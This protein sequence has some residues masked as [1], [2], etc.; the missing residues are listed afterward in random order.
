MHVTVLEALAYVFGRHEMQSDDF[1]LPV[2]LEAFPGGQL[3]Q[4]VADDTP[5]AD[6]YVATGHDTQAT[7]AE[8]RSLVSTFGVPCW[9]VL[10]KSQPVA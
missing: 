8:T 9:P 1:V 5:W 10:H 6:E 2:L 3:V 4:S 7:S